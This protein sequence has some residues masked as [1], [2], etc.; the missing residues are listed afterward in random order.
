MRCVEMLEK[1]DSMGKWYFGLF[2][3]YVIVTCEKMR[4]IRE[5]SGNLKK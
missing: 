1:L 3:Q 2:F 4:Y 5:Y